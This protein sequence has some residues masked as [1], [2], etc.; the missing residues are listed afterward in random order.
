[1]TPPSKSAI[2]MFSA[3]DS[4]HGTNVPATPPPGVAAL[5]RAAQIVETAAYDVAGD[6]PAAVVSQLIM[7]SAELDRLAGVLAKPAR[8]AT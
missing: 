7:I 8:V 6:H 4:C 5:L 2:I 1:M 3:C